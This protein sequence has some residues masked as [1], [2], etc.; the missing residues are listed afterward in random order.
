MVAASLVMGVGACVQGAIG[1]G[2]NVVAAPLLVLI[3]PGFVPGPVSV[4]TYVLNLFLVGRPRGTPDRGIRWALLGYVPG[5]VTAGLVLTVVD[6]GGLSVLFAVLVVLAVAISFVGLDVRPTPQTLGGAGVVSGF[7]GTVSSIGG[8]PVAL[9]YQHADGPTLRATL[10]RYFLAS[11][12]IGL[13]VLLAVGRLGG[14]EW[15]AAAGLLP[16]VVLG[17]ALAP[18]LAGHIDRGAVRPYVLGLSAVAAL[19]VLVRELAG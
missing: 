7:M 17:Y 12:T 15:L 19:G 2:A 9:L 16:G 14:D 11:G 4:A 13:L 10:P 1:F 5:A 6:E 8:P 18:R 3:D